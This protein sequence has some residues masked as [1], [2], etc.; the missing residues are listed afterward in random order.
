VWPAGLALTATEGAGEVQTPLEG[1][2]ADA[3]ALGSPVLFRHAK[4]GEVMERF[5][6]VLLVR[7]GAIVDRVPTYRGE[8]LSFV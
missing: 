1:D 3:V 6:E 7:D 8:G 4:A 2:G 5:R